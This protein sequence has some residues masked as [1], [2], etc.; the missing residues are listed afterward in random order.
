MAVR[1]RHWWVGVTGKVSVQC[2]EALL[3]RRLGTWG[4]KGMGD[5]CHL[6]FTSSKDNLLARGFLS[7]ERVLGETGGPSRVWSGS[8]SC[9]VIRIT[10]IASLYKSSLTSYLLNWNLQGWGW[11][12]CIF[13]KLTRQTIVDWET[14]HN[15]IQERKLDWCLDF[16]K[17]IKTC[18]EYWGKF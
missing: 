9:L 3:Q 18:W 2:Y 10:S 4:L 1:A 16:L 5:S 6:I 11:R 17:S 8:K 12:I 7:R 14:R 13:W 15:K